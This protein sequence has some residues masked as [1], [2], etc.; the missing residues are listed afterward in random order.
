MR[1]VERVYGP[2]GKPSKWYVGS[3]FFFGVYEG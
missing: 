1:F 3:R 2:D